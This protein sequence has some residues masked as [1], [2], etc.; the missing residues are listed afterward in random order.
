MTKNI[1]LDRSTLLKRSLMAFSGVLVILM[2][3]FIPASHDIIPVVAV[4]KLVQLSNDEL[5]DTLLENGLIVPEGLDKE[6]TEDAVK[7][8]VDGI[9]QGNIVSGPIPFSYTKLAELTEQILDMT[10][11]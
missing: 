6:Y 7:M 8:I 11:S 1:F 3:L 5:L 9:Q 10:D 2:L 4:D